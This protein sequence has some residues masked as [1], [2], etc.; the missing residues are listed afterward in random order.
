M[1]DEGEYICTGDNVVGSSSASAVIKVR[2]PPE[3]VITPR[4]Y[5]AVTDGNPISV[6]C[7]AEGYPEPWVVIRGKNAPQ[8]LLRDRLI[9]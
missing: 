4:N 7:R 6:D 5:M 1:N 8:S 3:I 9:L 2:S